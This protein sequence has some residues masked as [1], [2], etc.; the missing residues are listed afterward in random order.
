MTRSKRGAK[1]GESAGPA[2]KPGHGWF[3]PGQ[4]KSFSEAGE[5]FS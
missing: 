3:Q 2:A 1:V 4:Q 5:A